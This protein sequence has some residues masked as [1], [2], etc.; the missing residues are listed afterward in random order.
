MSYQKIFTLVT[1]LH[2]RTER[3]MIDWETTANPQA[4]TTSS[5]NYSM[6]V[7]EDDVGYYFHIYS[8][9]DDLVERVSASELNQFSLNGA[10]VLVSLHSMA[11]RQAK[12]VDKAIDEILK[13]F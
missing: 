5:A 11:R 10:D 13:S 12:G 3:G 9:D 4:F 8:E 7:S 6:I 2:T 1:Q